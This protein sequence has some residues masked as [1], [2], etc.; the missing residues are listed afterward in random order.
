M[1]QA[2]IQ[3]KGQEIQRKAAKDQVDAQLK[4][5]QLQV[6]RERI[7]QQAQT[8][9]MRIQAQ[10][11]QAAARNEHDHDLERTRLGVQTAIEQARLRKGQQ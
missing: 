9:A 1:Q 2:E 3:Q 7:M 10:K 6:E 11:E 4:A 5:Q 8:D